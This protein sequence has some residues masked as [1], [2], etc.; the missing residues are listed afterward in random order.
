MLWR[1]LP[2]WIKLASDAGETGTLTFE[3]SLQH[4]SHYFEC[5]RVLPF[6]M[7]KCKKYIEQYIDNRATRTALGQEALGAFTGYSTIMKLEGA[8]SKIITDFISLKGFLHVSFT[9]I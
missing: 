6:L 9:N 2:T 5:V 7:N 4:H 8:K 1:P 3:L